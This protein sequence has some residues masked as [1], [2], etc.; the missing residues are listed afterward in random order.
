MDFTLRE[1]TDP[2]NLKAIRALRLEAWKDTLSEAA[3]V[4]MNND[5]MDDRSRHWAVFVDGSIVAAARLSI[6]VRHDD[7]VD[8][9]LFEKFDVN[10]ALPVGSLNRCVVHQD[11]RKRGFARALDEPRIGAAKASNCK[12]LLSIRGDKKR[13]D[14]LRALG[15]KFV[16]HLVDRTGG[17]FDGLDCY[18]LKLDFS[19]DV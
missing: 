9:H 13:A 12:S 7:V 14:D 11:F 2:D 19:S 5:P 17:V 4:D 8:A 1:V 15:F 6:H 10:F 3:L 18:L 16:G